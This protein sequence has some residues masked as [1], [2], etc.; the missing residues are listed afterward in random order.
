MLLFVDPGCPAINDLISGLDYAYPNAVK[1]G[2]IAGQHSANHG[3][4][5][6][7]EETTVAYGDKASGPNHILPTNRRARFSSPLT[8]EAFRKV[9]SVLY[10]SEQR[11][12]A[13]GEDIMAFAEVEQLQAHA[14]SIEARIR[15]N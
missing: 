6:L 12:R 8:A 15:K 11:L 4:L 14:K 2:G 3:S 9:T 5:F 13:Q 7:G 1:V 10:Y